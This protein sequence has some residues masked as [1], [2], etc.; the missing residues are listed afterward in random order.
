MVL[1]RRPNPKNGGKFDQKA[2]LRNFFFTVKINK[3]EIVR[4]KAKRKKI[5]KIDKVKKICSCKKPDKK[6]LL[7]F[8]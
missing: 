7:Q 5:V 4:I 2:I 6:D 3:F 8:S 1:I